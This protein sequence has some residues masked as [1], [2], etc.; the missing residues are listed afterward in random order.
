MWPQYL[1]QQLGNREYS[2]KGRCCFTLRLLLHYFTRGEAFDYRSRIYF[3]QTI[4]HITT[5]RRNFGKNLISEGGSFAAGEQ[6][7]KKGGA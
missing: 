4:I 7:F 5:V 3:Q 2:K 6:N 1:K